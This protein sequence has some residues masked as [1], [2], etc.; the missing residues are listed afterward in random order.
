M[1]A[2]EL[3][4]LADDAKMKPG[5]KRAFLSGF[6]TTAIT[7]REQVAIVA[8]EAAPLQATSM[9]ATWPVVI[10]KLAE[11][12]MDDLAPKLK[13]EGYD[14]M[15][16]FDASD[17]EALSQIADMLELKAGHKAKFVK[18]FSEGPKTGV[19]VGEI[20]LSPAPQPTTSSTNATNTNTNTNTNVVVNVSGGGGDQGDKIPCGWLQGEFTSDKTKGSCCC[21]IAPIVITPVGADA[22][23]MRIGH[24]KGCCSEGDSGALTFTRQ[25][26]TNN[27]TPMSSSEIRFDAGCCCGDPPCSEGVLDRKFLQL[28]I[29]VDENH[30]RGTNGAVFKKNVPSDFK[31]G[32]ATANASGGAPEVQEMER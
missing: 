30:L 7:V 16:A 19:A 3:G 1:S 5:H 32:D 14:D 15:S 22:F 13:A 29:M 11:I 17:K 21:P 26:G 24:K 25:G 8:Q 20:A 23:E 27:F 10:S 6:G 4:E 12:G 28:M 31:R 2:E 18:K 9:S